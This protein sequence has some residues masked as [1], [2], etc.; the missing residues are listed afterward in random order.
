[1]VGK[2]LPPHHI[3]RIDMTVGTTRKNPMRHLGT[4]ISALCAANAW[5][6]VRLSKRYVVRIETGGLSHRQQSGPYPSKSD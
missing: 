3:D 4:I 2:Q 1:L 5:S 6:F